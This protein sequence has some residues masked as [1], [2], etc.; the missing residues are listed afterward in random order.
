MKDNGKIKMHIIGYNIGL[1]I[2]KVKRIV[3]Q[4]KLKKHLENLK[5]TKK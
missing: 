5:N 3:K 1:R 2:D 4:A